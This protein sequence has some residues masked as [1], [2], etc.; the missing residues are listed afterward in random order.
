MAPTGLHRGLPERGDGD[1]PSLASS[2]GREHASVE[3]PRRYLA[4]GRGEYPGLCVHTLP[5]RAS[6]V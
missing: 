3:R 4:S 1:A 2:V 5:D 6:H